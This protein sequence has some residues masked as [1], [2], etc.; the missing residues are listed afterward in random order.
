MGGKMGGAPRA[1]ADKPGV[2]E[3]AAMALELNGTS[4]EAA[5]GFSGANAEIL[6]RF[7]GGRPSLLLADGTDL[8]A[9]PRGTTDQ[10]GG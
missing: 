8:S 2:R 7:S 9:Q 4:R 6:K 10:L 5:T 1:D 3:I